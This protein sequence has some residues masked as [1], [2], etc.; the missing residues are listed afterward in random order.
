MKM[1]KKEWFQYALLGSIAITL[2]LTGLHT[3]VIGFAQ[4]GILET[5]LMNPDLEN[6]ATRRNSSSGSDP[7]NT[8]QSP[9]ASYDMKLPQKYGLPSVSYF[10]DHLNLSANYFGDLVKKETGKSALDHI[11]MKLIDI[12]KDRIFDTE[13]TISQIA[14]ELGFKYPQHFNRM[15][16]KNTGHTPKEYRSLN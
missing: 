15:F 2:Y 4:R 3:E 5:G 16:K 1:V 11:H 7:Q 8:Q 6:K 12:A 13:S 9:N 10:A 14:Y